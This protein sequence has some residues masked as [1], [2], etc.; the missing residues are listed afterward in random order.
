MESVCRNCNPHLSHT[1]W[2]VVVLVLLII[3]ALYTIIQQQDHIHSIGWLELG[4]YHNVVFVVLY[5]ASISSLGGFLGWG[6]TNISFTGSL[7]LWGRGSF[8]FGQL[9]LSGWF[10]STLLDNQRIPAHLF[11]SNCNNIRWIKT[12]CS[13]LLSFHPSAKYCKRRNFIAG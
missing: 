12:Y 5:C 7:L 1:D 2:L 13:H 9:S 3:H 11:S 8:W 4:Q 10:I 6:Y